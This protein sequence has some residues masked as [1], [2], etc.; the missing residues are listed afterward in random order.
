MQSPHNQWVDFQC[1]KI[2]LMF[3]LFTHASLWLGIARFYSYT[4]G[5]LHWQW[6][7]VVMVPVVTGIV[8]AGAIVIPVVTGVVSGW[9]AVVPM[10]PDT[11][12]TEVTLAWSACPMVI[13]VV[14]VLGLTCFS[15]VSITAVVVSTSWLPPVVS[16]C[17]SDTPLVTMVVSTW[18]ILLVVL[19]LRATAVESTWLIVVPMMKYSN[20]YST[21]HCAI[22]WPKQNSDLWVIFPISWR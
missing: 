8:S 1:T 19:V 18:F 12:P 2:A 13:S 4:S 11:V 3:T 7:N 22:P 16:A 6:G 20:T 21:Y 17:L 5:L 15:V 9:L 14:T 10:E